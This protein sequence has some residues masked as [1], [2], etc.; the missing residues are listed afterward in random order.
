MADDTFTVL[1]AVATVNR[2]TSVTYQSD[3]FSLAL[4]DLAALVKAQ[5]GVRVAAIDLGGWD[6]HVDEPTE[7]QAPASTLAKGLAAFATDL[8]SDLDR[9]L[10]LVM[11]EFGRRVAENGG[12]GTDHGHGGAMLALGGSV[13]GGQVLL[14]D[15]LWPGLQPSQLDQGDLKVTTDFRDSFAEVLHRHM[16][17]SALGGI[18]PNFSPSTSRYPGLFV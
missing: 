10:V 17:L 7:F 5:I 1:D 18:F 8:G 13:A 16:G 9:T 14:K 2:S 15:D 6:H 12:R 11:S 3:N 4:R